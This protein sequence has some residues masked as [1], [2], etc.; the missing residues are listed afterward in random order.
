MLLLEFVLTEEPT[1]VICDLCLCD[2]SWEFDS[3]RLKY[4][5]SCIMRDATVPRVPISTGGHPAISFVS[6]VT[7]VVVD[8]LCI[9]SLVGA[10]VEEA[11]SSGL[12]RVV[13]VVLF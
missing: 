2:L 7:R 5:I 1:S 9:L 4:S 11:K 8:L 13:L 12:R 6:V 3:I 10:A